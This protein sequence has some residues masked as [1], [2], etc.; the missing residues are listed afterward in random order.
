MRCDL[1]DNLAEFGGGLVVRMGPPTVIG[2]SFRRNVATGSGGAVWSDISQGRYINCSI[3]GNTATDSG[4]GISAQLSTFEMVNCLV[5]GNTAGCSGGA[6][7]AGGCPHG[8]ATGGSQ[9]TL[10]NCTLADNRAG[11]GRAVQCFSD[12]SAGRSPSTIQVGNSLLRDGG[13]EIRNN[14]GSMIEVTFSNVQGGYDGPGN[15]DVNPPF[16]SEGVWDDRDTPE[17]IFDDRWTEGDYR[18]PADSPCIDVDYG[19]FVPLDATDLDADGD[20]L[21]VIPQDIRGRPRVVEKPGQAPDPNSP[22]QPR[23][24]MGAYEYQDSRTVFRFWSPVFGRHFYTVSDLEKKRLIREYGDIWV[25]EEGA[26]YETFADGS[27]PDTRPVHRFWS[28]LLNTHFYTIHEQEKMLLLQDYPHVWVY[29]GTVFY[30]HAEGQQP[31]LAKPIYRFWSPIFATHFYTISEQERDM[32][33]AE[34]SFIWTYEGI[35]WY[36]YE[37][38]EQT[39]PP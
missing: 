37:L 26:G 1:R 36:A 7:N 34:Y 11:A 14:D 31:S 3:C 39:S 10:M 32:L 22:A 21:E 12:A 38:S 20:I 30:A 18:V 19:R 5:C 16:A 23:V 24:D 29:E 8:S 27:N 2:C 35:A 4:G 28:P 15:I 9:I 33:I 17:D 6:L 25:Y 13:D